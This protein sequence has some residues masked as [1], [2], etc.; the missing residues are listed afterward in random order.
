[1]LARPPAR[2]LGFIVASAFAAL[3][4]VASI[5]V[6]PCA[7]ADDDS[8]AITWDHNFSIASDL[9][10]RLQTKSIGDWYGSQQVVAGVE[11]EQNTLGA[12]LK[13]KLDKFRAVGDVDLVVFGYQQKLNGVAALSHVEEVQ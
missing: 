7:Q 8:G 11:R 5:V 9:R 10:F 13:V 2:R 3:A 6:A 4:V 12:K 1:M